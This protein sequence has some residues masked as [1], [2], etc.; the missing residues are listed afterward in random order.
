MYVAASW[1]RRIYTS[2]PLPPPL[3]RLPDPSSLSPTSPSF[4]LPLP[5]PFF[6]PLPPSPLPSQ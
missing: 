4:P 6:S 2:P 3:L 1:L 5:P